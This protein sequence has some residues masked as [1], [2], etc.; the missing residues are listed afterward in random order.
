[1][2]VSDPQF[3]TLK[4]QVENLY[5]VLGLSNEA[6][7]TGLDSLSDSVATVNP[8]AHRDPGNEQTAPLAAHGTFTGD[9]HHMSDMHCTILTWASD[10]QPDGVFIEWSPD[11]VNPGTG[12][13]D[14]SPMQV[15]NVGGVWAVLDVE[16]I[17]IQPYMRVFVQNGAT[18]QG[19]VASSMCCTK[20][21]FSGLWSGLSDPLTALVTAAVHRAV[22][23]AQRTD[24]SFGNV[25][26]DPNGLL[27][28]ASPAWLSKLIVGTNLPQTIKT[29][30][31]VLHSITCG[32]GSTLL[33]YDDP[34]TGILNPILN[35]GATT[36]LLGP[37]D[38][39][40]TNGLRVVAQAGKNVTVAYA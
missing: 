36:G 7:F 8:S 1:M 29:G 26:A 11:G 5:G 33:V 13:F 22:L 38:I 17:A 30:P 19:F 2:G 6:V 31:G 18:P 21:S 27:Q 20:G 15:K 35:M 37:L 32:T 16:N 12:T 24:G 40:F 28:V 4:T 9:W 34:G 25:I 14:V 3:R 23:V 39:A 10:V